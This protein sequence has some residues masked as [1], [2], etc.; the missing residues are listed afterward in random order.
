M[1]HSKTVF[2]VCLVLVSGCTGPWVRQSGE[3][4]FRASVDASFRYGSI[5]GFAQVPRGGTPGTTSSRRPAFKELDVD[6]VAIA[7][8]SASVAWANHII[9]GGV[10][11]VRLSGD[12]VLDRDLVSRGI[13]FPA[14]STVSADVTLD[15][16]RAGYKYRFSYA[17]ER[18]DAISL[19]PSAGVA[20]LDFEYGLSGSAGM[21]VHRSFPEAAPQ[22]GLELEWSPE[23]RFAISGEVLASLP[24]S[25]LPFILSARLTGRCRLWGRRSR[26]G[27]AF[28]GVGFDRIEFKDDQ[29]V[30]NHIEADMGPLLLIG[31]EVDF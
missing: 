10:R 14:G 16:Y 11:V 25:T 23:G 22:F 26:G 27:A 30:P 4:R 31:L 18:G 5:D 8:T 1:L 15:W 13:T 24:L 17:N 20:V 2:G 7:D 6:T 29:Q 19:A 9:Y 28:L 3:R 12:G 21:S